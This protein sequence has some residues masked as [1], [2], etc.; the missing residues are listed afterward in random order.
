MTYSSLFVD[1]GD[2]AWDRLA[3]DTVREAQRGGL[4]TRITAG[5]N[6]VSVVDVQIDDES[7]A[8]WRG[9]GDQDSHKDSG[10]SPKLLQ[11]PGIDDMQLRKV[12][13]DSSSNT[14]HDLVRSDAYAP[15]YLELQ[16]V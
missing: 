15:T 10:I 2:S 5:R 12:G 8:L 1:N 3:S 16:Q 4:V 11:L 9:L 6:R 13:E 7:V 14:S